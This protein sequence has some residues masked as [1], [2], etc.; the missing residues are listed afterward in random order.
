MLFLWDI[1]GTLIQAKGAGR[2]AM[3]GAFSRNFGVQDA[4]DNINMAGGL[5]LDF[6][7]VVFSRYHIG[8]S[9]LGRFLK[10]YYDLLEHELKMGTARKIP[11]VQEVMTRLARDS[12]HY[13]ALGTGNFETGARIKLKTFALNDYFPIGGFC[14]GRMQ[15]Y[16]VL[17]LAVHRA[18]S[19]YGV[20]VRPE[21]VLVIG[22]T[23]R[24]IQAA[25]KI[26]AKVLSVATGGNT[27][28]ELQ[29][30]DPDWVVRDLREMPLF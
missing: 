17:R 12:R 7:D 22:D 11:G 14:E 25:R 5:D 15:R 26:G 30:A 1:D 13:H 4:F 6:I 20:N 28:E 3:N 9:F 16:E 18:E 2:R 24:D 8:D 19:Y 10:D 23:L 27:Y 29:A 21:E